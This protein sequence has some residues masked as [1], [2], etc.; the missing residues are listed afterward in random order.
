MPDWFIALNGNNIDDFSYQLTSIG[1]KN[2]LWIE[3]EINAQGE[4]I[5]GGEKD[6]KVSYIIMGTRH[7]IYAEENQMEV[8]VEKE[9]V[10]KKGEY[11]Y[12]QYYAPKDKKVISNNNELWLEQ[13]IELE[14]QQSVLSKANIIK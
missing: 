13:G 4:F 8:E 5:I 1:K 12:P 2:D 10:G 6:L 14:V 11:M 3:E 7:D 9:S